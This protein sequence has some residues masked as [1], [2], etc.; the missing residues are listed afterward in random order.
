MFWTGNAWKGY[1]QHQTVAT[2]QQPRAHEDVRTKTDNVKY[3]QE[4]PCNVT[5]R[6]NTKTPG[7]CFSASLLLEEKLRGQTKSLKRAPNHYAGFENMASC[8]TSCGL[9]ELRS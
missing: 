3:N 4:L 2:N 5:S 1:F 7:P 9:F 8:E 6:G